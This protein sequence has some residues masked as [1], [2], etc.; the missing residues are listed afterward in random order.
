[1]VNPSLLFKIIGKYETEEIGE[2]NPSQLLAENYDVIFR[3]NS[4]CYKDIVSCANLV[5]ASSHHKAADLANYIQGIVLSTPFS[6]GKYLDSVSRAASMKY[7][8]ISSAINAHLEDEFKTNHPTLFNKLTVLDYENIN[9]PFE[10]K[11]SRNP[12]IVQKFVQQTNSC[13]TNSP[14]NFIEDMTRDA[15][16]IYL[17]AHQRNSRSINK[18]PDIGFII[19]NAYQSE[20]RKESLLSVD[21]MWVNNKNKDLVCAIVQSVVDLSEHL[22][23]DIIDKSM[24]N[25][26]LR[27]HQNVLDVYNQEQ[28]LYKL[29]HIPKMTRYN[30]IHVP[31]KNDGF[32]IIQ[33][34]KNK[35][36]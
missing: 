34:L 22:N 8:N 14:L 4:Y 19:L 32:Y 21:T 7:A 1:M 2:K 35:C 18:L 3:K 26:Y 28:D 23:I 9:T 6:L 10:I 15:A 30:K 27:E 16:T 17:L 31:K 25:N 20:N 5:D 29:G 24:S 36:K 11:N 33:S 12:L 13:L